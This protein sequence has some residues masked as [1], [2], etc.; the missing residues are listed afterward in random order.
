[1][2]RGDEVV[3]LIQGRIPEYLR[4]E[5]KGPREKVIKGDTPNVWREMFDS[6]LM[7]LLAPVPM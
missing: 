7:Q 4:K 5:I 3:Q 1:M 2:V 6:A